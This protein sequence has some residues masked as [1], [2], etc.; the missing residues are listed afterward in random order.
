MGSIIIPLRTFGPT[1]MQASSL[2]PLHFISPLHLH[3]FRHNYYKHEELNGSRL[4]Q[5]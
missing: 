1:H 5:P 2:S 3:V 4:V